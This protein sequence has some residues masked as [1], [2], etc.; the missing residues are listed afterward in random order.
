MRANTRAADY[1]GVFSA[2]HN[3]RG[4]APKA[5][6]AGEKKWRA[7]QV[8]PLL[9]TAALNCTRSP[10]LNTLALHARGGLA[11]TS[12]TVVFP[13]WLRT[14]LLRRA[15]TTLTLIAAS[16]HPIDA[17]I[18]SWVDATGSLV[19]SNV[20]QGTNLG[21]RSY[22]V[23]ESD[24][25]RATRAVE[26]KRTRSFDDVI[27]THATRSGVRAG[28]VRAVIQVESA[29]NPR[30]I[31]SKGAMGLMQLMPATARQ[32]G[33]SNAF[34]PSENVR[35]GV[36]YLRQL[37]DRYG[38]DERLAL[39]AYNAGPGAVDRFGQ[40]VPPF[41]ETRD[42]VRRIGGLAGTGSVES[43][44][45]PPP[46]Q[47]FRQVEIIDGREVVLYTDQAPSSR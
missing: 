12:V 20:P 18:Y 10:G 6:S 42:Y 43:P 32:F 23:P 46:P 35:A 37:L 40:S 29:F 21:M 41:A 28:L 38:G 44:A 31:S 36:A 16:T 7:L 11:D 39:A 17:Q 13:T 19:V 8:E 2:R 27:R 15:V 45:S 25:I 24:G 4:I 5:W 3:F 30:A 34:D 33:V 1:Y 47:I 22:D 14:S 9:R 26:P